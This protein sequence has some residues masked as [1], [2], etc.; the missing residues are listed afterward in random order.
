MDI[1][2]FFS[3]NYIYMGI[4][5]EFMNKKVKIMS[6][7]EQFSEVNATPNKFVDKSH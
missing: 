6:E 5:I 2:S 1:H 3:V 7:I 4:E